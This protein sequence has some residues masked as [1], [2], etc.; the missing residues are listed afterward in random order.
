MRMISARWRNKSFIACRS[1]LFRGGCFS[2]PGRNFGKATKCFKNN[3]AYANSA[4]VPDLWQRA[5]AVYWEITS[6][7]GGMFSYVD[8]KDLAD[9]SYEN[10]LER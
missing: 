10:E 7:S 1:S 3:T 2:D 4:A 9:V 5:L 6:Y 8:S